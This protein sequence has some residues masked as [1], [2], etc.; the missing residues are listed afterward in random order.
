MSADDAVDTRTTSTAG[1]SLRP[2][3]LRHECRIAFVHTGS[4]SHLAVLEDPVLRALGLEDMYAPE[5]E[6]WDLD[7]FDAVYVAARLHPAVL[8]YIAPMLLEVLD[9]PGGRMVVDGG[10]RPEQWLPQLDLPDEESLMRYDPG[11]F[12]AELVVSGLEASCLHGAGRAPAAT[13]V[14]HRTVM[15]LR[16][17]GTDR[18]ARGRDGTGWVPVRDL[19]SSGRAI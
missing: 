14:L 11:T 1:A 4:P 3:R 13:Q 6:G 8:T 10:N 19:V 18:P 16:A 9:R 15:W 7:P 12:P 17:A 2:R 5:L